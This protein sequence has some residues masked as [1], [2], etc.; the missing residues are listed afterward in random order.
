M[1]KTFFEILKLNIPVQTEPLITD[2][3]EPLF[4]AKCATC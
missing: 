1:D 2:E 3:T 4:S